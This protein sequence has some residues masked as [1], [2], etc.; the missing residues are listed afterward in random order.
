MRINSRPFGGSSS[1][2]VGYPR[3]MRIN[4]AAVIGATRSGLQRFMRI[5]SFSAMLQNARHVLQQDGCL[6]HLLWIPMN[7]RARQ[8]ARGHA[9]NLKFMGIDSQTAP[10]KLRGCQGS[11][12]IRKSPLGMPGHVGGFMRINGFSHGIPAHPPFP[13]QAQGPRQPCPA[14]FQVLSQTPGVC[15]RAPRWTPRRRHHA[16]CNSH[17]N[18]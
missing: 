12:R 16:A 18:T 8:E 17:W 10:E 3:F 6:R 13:S 15:R 7:S 5:N 9:G 1:G 2:P 11:V 4:R 14:G